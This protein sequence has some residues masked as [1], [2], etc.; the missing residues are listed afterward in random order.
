[1]LIGDSEIVPNDVA[2][3]DI[4]AQQFEVAFRQDMEWIDT[5]PF[6][7]GTSTLDVLEG[8][9]DLLLFQQSF[10]F[11]RQAFANKMTVKRL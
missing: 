5:D 4:Q 10:G 6:E 8:I 7:K 11:V 3:L 1:M 2:L 9:T